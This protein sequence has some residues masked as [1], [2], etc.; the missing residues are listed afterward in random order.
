MNNPISI[1]SDE[2][3]TRFK[4]QVKRNKRLLVPLREVSGKIVGSMKI[5]A[6]RSSW[7]LV[8]PYSL[9][10]YNWDSVRIKTH[11][12]ILTVG[13]Q[14]VWHLWQHG[15][16]SI[17]GLIGKTINQQHL[18]YINTTIENN[19][20]IWVLSDGDKASITLAGHIAGQLS[21]LR[22]TRHIFSAPNRVVDLSSLALQKLFRS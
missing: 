19:G 12:L 10:L 6:E 14:T 3:I 8:A 11:D 21:A 16:P 18:T 15:F 9:P 4:I 17:V 13:I 1:P 2:I 22:F 20:L 7:S 5:C